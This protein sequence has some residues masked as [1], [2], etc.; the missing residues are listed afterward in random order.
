[1]AYPVLLTSGDNG[2][3]FVNVVNSKQRVA[4]SGE[5]NNSGDVIGVAAPVFL[6]TTNRIWPIGNRSVLAFC[7]VKDSF[8]GALNVELSVD[9]GTTFLQ[10]FTFP[11]S[12]EGIP[13]SYSDFPLC[14][15]AARFT[16]IASV[17]FNSSGWLEIR[18]F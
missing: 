13:D 11:L 10:A 5:A 4:W 12:G 14:G 17:A 3:P 2:L 7:I 16:L 1:M 15:S 6:G 8:S 9:G 18:S